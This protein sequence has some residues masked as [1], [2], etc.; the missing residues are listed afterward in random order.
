M[1]RTERALIA[2][3]PGRADDHALKPS[4]GIE[5]ITGPDHARRG[6]TGPAVLTAQ[7]TAHGVNQ[8]AIGKLVRLDRFGYLAPAGEAV[9]EVVVPVDHE[10]GAGEQ[11]PPSS[12]PV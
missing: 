4:R 2:G 9:C 10:L 6:R 8:P 5:V 7:V 11:F 12:G 3:G 1:K